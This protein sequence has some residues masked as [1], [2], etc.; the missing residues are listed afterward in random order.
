MTPRL[1]RGFGDAAVI[2]ATR[3]DES[4]GDGLPKKN[5]KLQLELV[6]TWGSR[7]K[8]YEIVKFLI[9]IYRCNSC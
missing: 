4:C 9:R 2:G 5:Y 8:L 7:S 3:R 6:E 1:S